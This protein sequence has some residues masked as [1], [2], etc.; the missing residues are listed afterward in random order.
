MLQVLQTFIAVGDGGRGHVPPKFGEKVFFGQLL[1]KI[2]AFFAQKSC[3]NSGILLF[4]SGKYHSGILIIFGQ[5]SC[6]IRAFCQF[7]IHIFRCIARFLRIDQ[8]WRNQVAPW[9]GLLHTVPEN[10][11]QIGP[12]VSRNLAD[13]ETNE[14]TKKSIEIENNT[15]SRYYRGGLIN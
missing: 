2:R 8:K 9:L 6:K 5:E 1:W 10:L 14:Q 13:K 11:M 7:F 15:P 12:A 4:L 3:K